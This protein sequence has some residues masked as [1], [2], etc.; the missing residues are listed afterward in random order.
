M[1]S[2][3]DLLEASGYAAARPKEFE[4]LLTILNSEVRLIT[5]TDP[6]GV[7]ERD[8]LRQLDSIIN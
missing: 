3:A 8:R 1:Q 5:P 4:E 6:A 2:H 7:A